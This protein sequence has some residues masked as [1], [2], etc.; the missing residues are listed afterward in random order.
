M[1]EI[2]TE[3]TTKKRNRST[4]LI[5]AFPNGVADGWVFKV[6]KAFKSALDI[7]ET[8]KVV[9]KI[10]HKQWTQGWVFAFDIGDTFNYYEDGTYKYSIQVQFSSPS[11]YDEVIENAVEGY[12][13][14]S[15][16]IQFA[17]FD[18]YASRN[19][20]LNEENR[21]V[22]AVEFV[23]ILKYGLKNEKN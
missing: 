17:K 20:F 3:F 22:T 14:K 8:D 6:V 2:S 12:R 10:K 21:A 9:D 15:G 23:N 13:F 1:L 18:I 19:N 7:K 5:A 16:G 11:G 4:E